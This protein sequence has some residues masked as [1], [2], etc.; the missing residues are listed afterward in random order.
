[1][2]KKITLVI[3]TIFLLLTCLLFISSYLE[4][5]NIIFKKCLDVVPNENLIEVARFKVNIEICNKQS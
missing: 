4:R 2:N 1:M 3:L 5:K